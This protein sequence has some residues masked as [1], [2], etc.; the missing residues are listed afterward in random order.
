[1]ARLCTYELLFGS[2][3]ATTYLSVLMIHA[4]QLR[5][6]QHGDDTLGYAPRK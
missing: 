4:A 1:M 6:E 2:S 3:F 5:R